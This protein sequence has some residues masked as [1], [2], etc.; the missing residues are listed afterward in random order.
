MGLLEDGGEMVVG[1]L[2]LA[3]TLAAD[4]VAL[5]GTSPAETQSREKA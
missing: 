5:R 2:A 3:I 4:P 1:S